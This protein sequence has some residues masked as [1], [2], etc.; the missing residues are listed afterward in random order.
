VSRPPTA[1][2]GL[3][4]AISRGSGGGFSSSLL[5]PLACGLE[6]ATT[7]AFARFMGLDPPINL[8]PGVFARCLRERSVGGSGGSLV[9][10]TKP[11]T[12]AARLRRKDH[13]SM[14]PQ[15]IWE[16]S[17]DRDGLVGGSIAATTP[18]PRYSQHSGPSE[19][20]AL[21]ITPNLSSW[22][23]RRARCNRT[24]AQDTRSVPWPASAF[25]LG[26]ERPAG[27]STSPPTEG[28]SL[29]GLLAYPQNRVWDFDFEERFLVTFFAREKLLAESVRE[30]DRAKPPLTLIC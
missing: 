24:R 12:R 2:I 30:A 26:D 22:R 21:L 27:V 29:H 20:E 23:A 9:T 16:R 5:Q 3:P 4:V 25:G 28:A 8:R 15:L 6:T 19:L 11:H 7:D 14:L 1:C 18:L 13:S 10:E 17:P